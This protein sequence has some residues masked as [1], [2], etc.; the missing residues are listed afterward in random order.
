MFE[1]IRKWFRSPAPA[2]VL[3]AGADLQHTP[4]GLGYQILA[5][6]DGP[7][8]EAHE[9][10][11]VRYAG[12]TT[13]GKLFDASFPGTARFPLNRVIGGWTEGLQLI[14]AGGSLRLLIPP[15]LAYGARGAPPKIGPNATLV[16]L[17]ELVSI[18]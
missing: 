3:P 13:K 8:P 9:T 1:Q 4:S 2:F 6:G 16:F 12:W 18:G 10:V 7:Q 5:A 11:T 17:V 14:G 15:E